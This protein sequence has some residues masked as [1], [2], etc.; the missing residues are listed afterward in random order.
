MSYPGPIIPPVFGT[1]N[2]KDDDGQIIDEFFIETDT[3]PPL[4]DA[5]EPIDKTAAIDIPRITRIITK[6][7]LV[8]PTWSTP[9]QLLP[10]DSKRHGVGIRVWSP[11]LVATDGIR[12]SSDLGEVYSAGVILHGQV[13]PGDALSEHTG[14]LYATAANLTTT[15]VG[16]ASAPVFVMV[17]SVSE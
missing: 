10:S 7:Q 15:G 4:K 2:L 14:P 16:I 12:L 6:T 13:P 5:T 8:D 17:W 1:E 11:G 3:P 9:I